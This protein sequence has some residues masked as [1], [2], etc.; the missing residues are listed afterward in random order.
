M[1]CCLLIKMIHIQSKRC[2]IWG[3]IVVRATIH[4]AIVLGAILLWAIVGRG[5]IVQGEIVLEPFLYSLVLNSIFFFFRSNMIV[6]IID[7]MIRYN[8]KNTQS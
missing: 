7:A 4:G 6:Y 1:L 5:G 2:N 8:T 3:A